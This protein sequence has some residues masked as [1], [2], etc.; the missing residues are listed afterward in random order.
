MKLPALFSDHMVLQQGHPA[1][2]WGWALPQESVTV[3]IAGQTAQTVADDAGTWSVLL[4]PLTAGGPFELTVAGNETVTFHDVLVG[5]VWICSGQSNM[6][7]GIGV[8]QDA[9]IE[10]ANADHPTIRLFTVPK[11]VEAEPQQDV[12]SRW[13]VCS[14]ENIKSGVWGGFSAAAYYFG[15]KLSEELNVPIGLV[16]S[17]WGGTVAEAW[18][19]REA[20]LANDVTRDFVATLDEGLANYEENI[21]TYRTVLA[22]WED[23]YLPKDAG[24][25][26]L[27]RGWAAN[28][29]DTTDWSTM[30]LPR[31]WQSSGLTFSGVL[32]FRNELVVPDEWAGRD[33][34]LHIG[35][36]D[37]DDLTYFNGEQVGSL[38][39]FDDPMSWC[40]PRVY[41]IPGKLV[42]AGRNLIAVRVCSHAYDGGMRG[43][44]EEMYLAGPKN[45]GEERLSLVGNWRYAIEQNF[46]LVQPPATPPLP[47]GGD[48][49]N[50]PTMLFNAMLVPLVNYTI[51]GAIWYQ[52]E[53]NSS[54]AEQYRTLFPVMIRDWRYQ[55]GQGDFPFIFVQLANYIVG[56]STEQNQW[57]W[58]REAQL[59]AL[60]EPNTGMAVIADIGT[61]LDIHPTNKQ[62][63]G[64]RL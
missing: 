9:E 37:K 2:V 27:A 64:R 54:R 58:L 50:S 43:P 21:A 33:L 42:K 63:V 53:S 29:T 6:E 34:E 15:R 26:G 55:W 31:T 59:L 62:E 22:T 41:T 39:H 11:G 46:G 51:R 5:E 18:T 19:S 35:W 25:A 61:P 32:W 45:L 14:P 1:R 3:T 7:M 44:I 57:A 36:C 8:A 60:R 20:L 17:S 40:T 16:H 52:G 47:I 30:D 23:K 12:D 4:S 38:T 28:D 48:N 49:P 24:N 10:I 56:N 13:L